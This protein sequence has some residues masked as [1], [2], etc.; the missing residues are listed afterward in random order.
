MSPR[1]GVLLLVIGLAVLA[2]GYALGP[3][4]VATE[5]HGFAA[6]TPMFPGLAA[7]AAGAERIEIVAKGQHLTFVRATPDAAW[8]MAE[9]DDYPV[10]PSRIHALLT[11]LA[12]L[13][14]AEPRT[15][16]P[17][18]YPRLGLGDPDKPDSEATLVRVLGADGRVIA[19][20]VLGR[21]PAA[22]AGAAETVYVRR[23]DAAQTWLAEGHV[24]LDTD[25]Q[26]WLQRDVLSIDA[27]KIARITVRRGSE[28]LV[29]ARD[30]AALKLVEP[31]PPPPVDQTKLDE[32]ARA[33]DLL[34]FED[35]RR[36]DAKAAVLSVT[37][38]Q[39][40]GGPEITATEVG[41]DKEAWTRFAASGQGAEALPHLAGWDFRLGSFKDRLIAPSPESLKPPPEPQTTPGAQLPG[42]VTPG[43]PAH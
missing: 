43:A 20:A 40:K 2:A 21:R 37:T 34:T 5:R 15:G 10:Q 13:R 35:V 27:A 26:S 16:D 22:A 41:D 30:G 14:L 28:T 3:A 33:L 11:G 8:G 23:P 6:G 4:S 42:L 7:A 29:I 12:E 36:A 9:H 38:Y 18:M 19:A 24:P 17:A 1:A 25:G 39:V 32:T 31:N